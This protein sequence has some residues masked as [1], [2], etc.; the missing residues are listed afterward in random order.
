MI[1]ET[2]PLEEV[3]SWELDPLNSRVT[4]GPLLKAG[5]PMESVPLVS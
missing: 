1:H 2:L 3:I 5:G 4:F